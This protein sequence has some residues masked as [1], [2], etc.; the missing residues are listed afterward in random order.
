MAP[1][2]EILTGGLA[3]A[4][5]GAKLTKGLVKNVD[6]TRL[7]FSGTARE[8]TYRSMWKTNPGGRVRSLEEVEDL[9]SNAGVVKPDYIRFEIADNL[10]SDIYA[11]YT[12]LEISTRG[13]ST[14]A[15][16]DGTPYNSK[17]PFDLEQLMDENGQILVRLNREI[18]DSDDKILSVVIHELHE[19]VFL[20]N[21]YFD[22]L[23]NLRFQFVWR[24]K[25][26]SAHT[27]ANQMASA[28]FEMLK[29]LKPRIVLG[30]E[31]YFNP[32]IFPLFH[33][34]AGQATWKPY[35]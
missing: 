11:K 32:D 6:D 18:L 2:V 10:P 3:V 25:R 30:D 35:E 28:Y 14:K 8:F 7:I 13:S 1:I 4:K 22:S 12:H 26:S 24:Q 29:G 34:R 17:T 31:F 21:N 19:I 5:S 33:K 27:K 9:I 23:E 20:D 15:I 16:V